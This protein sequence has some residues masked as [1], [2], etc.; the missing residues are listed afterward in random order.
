MFKSNARAVPWCHPCWNAQK[1][2]KTLAKGDPS[3]KLALQRLQEQDYELYK[4]KIRACRIIDPAAAASGESGVTSVTSRRE[5][6]VSVITEVKQTLAFEESGGV[7][8]LKRAEFIHHMSAME[9]RGK[10]TRPASLIGW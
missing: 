4:A 2:L 3:A 6:M 7:R 9:S 10:R 1:A 5:A 8:W